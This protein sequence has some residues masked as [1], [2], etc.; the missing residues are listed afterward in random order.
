MNKRMSKVIVFVIVMVLAITSTVNSAF[1]SEMSFSTKKTYS[2]KIQENRYEDDLEG[3][4]GEEDVKSKTIKIKVPSGT[5]TID[6][7]DYVTS[8]TITITDSKKKTVK[9]IKSEKQ[10]LIEMGEE[11]ILHRVSTGVALSKGTYNITFKSSSKKNLYGYTSFAML[12][13]KSKTIDIM[14]QTDIAVT[15]DKTY[16]FAFNLKENETYRFAVYLRSYDI[17]HEGIE[18]VSYKILDK[19][20]KVIATMN[21]EGDSE[22]QKKLSAGDYTLQLTAQKDGIISVYATVD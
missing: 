15:N 16:K 18:M 2:L 14:N 11:A 20:G 1:A 9:T 7:K 6:S 12:S 21:D 13:N 10:T 8:Y 22:L 17:N 3:Y 4:Q 5:L 19:N